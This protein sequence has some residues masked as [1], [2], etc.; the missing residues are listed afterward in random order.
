MDGVFDCQICA[1]GTVWLGTRWG[2]GRRVVSIIHSGG[3]GVCHYPGPI[4]AVVRRSFAKRVRG[5]WHFADLRE[6]VENAAEAIH[7]ASPWIEGWHAFREVLYFDGRR[8]NG[9]RDA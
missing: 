6:A 7:A 8:Q 2:A 4:Q 5:L 1:T 3:H 9:D